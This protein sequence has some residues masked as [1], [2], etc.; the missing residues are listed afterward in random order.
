MLT[1]KE[2]PLYRRR[3]GTVPLLQA[4]SPALVPIGLSVW[5]AFSLSF[6]LANLSYLIPV[7]SDPLNLGWNLLGTAGVGWTPYGQA[8]FPWL[9]I[10]VLLAGL[11]WTS[12]RIG[13]TAE[14]IGG[15]YRLALPLWIVTLLLA[16]GALWLL[17]L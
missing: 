12:Q 16:A 9:T 10:S 1:Q 7:V 14:D 2:L 8:L 11:T 4:F 6:L 15:G 13:A 5:I 3:I 17:V